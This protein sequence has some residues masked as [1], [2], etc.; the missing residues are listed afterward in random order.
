MSKKLYSTRKWKNYLR[1]RQRYQLKRTRERRS[2]RRGTIPLTRRKARNLPVLNMAVPQN[3]SIIHNPTDSIKFLRE[4]RYHAK[5]NNLTLN[6]AAVTHISVDAI[7]ALIAEILSLR[8]TRVVN[9]YNP[10]NE[11]CRDLLIRSGFFDHVRS[12]QPLPPGQK[13]KIAPRKSYRVEGATAKQL[14]RIGTEAAFGS[15]TKSYS[16]YSALIE[17]MSNTHNHATGRREE[18]GAEMWYSTV[19]GDADTR[20][21]SYSFLDTGVGIFRSVRLNKIKKLYNKLFKG[22]DHRGILK[23]IL[24]G[25]V[26]SRTGLPFR[27]KGLPGIYKSF[28]AGRI[29]SLIIVSN[30]VYADVANDDYRILGVQFPGTLLYW[31]T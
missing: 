3:F 30:D 14:I 18:H 21:V 10:H 28:R 26:A 16:A 12:R 11:A 27:G 9:G 8:G 13:G 15:P 25:R 31:E 23:D 4:F 19:Y 22:E 7:T 20:T 17:C 6:L 24:H 2:R 29:K 5:N 1:S